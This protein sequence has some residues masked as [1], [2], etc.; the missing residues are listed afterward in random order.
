[1]VSLTVM[2]PMG[3]DPGDRFTVETDWGEMEFTVPEGIDYGDD[4][5]LEVRG[6]RRAL[7]VR[8]LCTCASLCLPVY[9]CVRVCVC[10]CEVFLQLFCFH[11]GSFAVLGRLRLNGPETT[12]TVASFC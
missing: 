7:S 10:V 11:F 4:I 12:A 9:L 6:V 5:L 8:T 2:C 3:C 1:M